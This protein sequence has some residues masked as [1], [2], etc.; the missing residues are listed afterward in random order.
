M[1]FEEKDQFHSL[2]I[3]EVIDSEK[4]GYL[5]A[6]TPPFL[7]TFEELTFSHVTI[8]AQIGTAALTSQYSIKR[9]QIQLESISFCEM[10]NF[11]TVW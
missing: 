3:S 11:R 8:T 4:Y 10:S 1:H 7:K 9:R 6:R 2:N 5:N